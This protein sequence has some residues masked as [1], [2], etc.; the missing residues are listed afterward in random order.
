[1][2]SASESSIFISVGRKDTQ[3]LRMYHH[4]PS[5]RANASS[6]TQWGAA[7]AETKVMGVCGLGACE[8]RSK[9]GGKPRA[10]PHHYGGI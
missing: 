7:Q 5:D 9:G 4:M 2:E 10:R 6:S 1:M 8:D 3:D